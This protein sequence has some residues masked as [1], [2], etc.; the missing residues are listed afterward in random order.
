[1]QEKGENTAARR[2]ADR[3]QNRQ[4]LYKLVSIITYKNIEI[5]SCICTSVW[6]SKRHYR[7]PPHSPSQSHQGGILYALVNRL[8]KCRVLGVIMYSFTTCFHARK[9]G[10]QTYFTH[11][12]KWIWSVCNY[13]V[14]M[15]AVVSY[16]N[17]QIKVILT[18]PVI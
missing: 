1:M 16:L 12:L 8:V 10:I 9:T 11:P 18:R 2:K 4:L 5:T 6:L 15:L 14:L 3:K 17:S 7:V 13:R